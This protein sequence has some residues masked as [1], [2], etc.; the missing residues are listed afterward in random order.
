MASS[1]PTRSGRRI[2]GR[3]TRLARLGAAA[4]AAT[5]AHAASAQSPAPTYARIFGDHA[6]LQRDRPIAIWGQARPGQ[7]VSVAMAGRSAGATADRDGRWRATLAAIPAGGP[8]TLS[9]SADGAATTLT[10]IMVGDVYLCGGQSNMEFPARQSTGAWNGFGNALN[11]DLRFATVAKDSENAPLADL[12]NPAPWQVASPD[13][14]GEASAVCYYMARS[15]QKS[16]H[17]PVGFVAS[18]WGGTTIQGWISGP[19]LATVKPYDRG[20][21]ALALLARDPAAALAGQDRQEQDWWN[22]HDPQARKE[23]AYVA[24]RFNDAAWPSFTPGKGWKAAQVPALADFDGVV[25][26]R[27]E[28]V[29]TAEQARAATRLSLGQVDAADSSWVN[30]RPVGSGT[31]WW[32]GRDYPVPAGTFRAGRNVIVLR[33]LGGS[34]GGG[35]VGDPAQRAIMSEHG[36]VLPLDGSWKYRRGTAMKGNT[37]PTAPWSVPSS[38]ATLF[39]GMIAPITGYG[40]K[41]AAWYQGESNAGAAREYATLLPLLIAD[42]RRQTATPDLPFLLVQLAGFGPVAPQPTQSGWAELR[43]VQAKVARADPHAGLATTIDVGDRFD[44]H[45]TQKLVVGERLA[46]AARAVA[47]GEAVVPGGPEAVSVS[48]S[49]AD[50]VVAF[51]N[52]DAGLRTYS[53]GEAIGFEVCEGD[54]CRFVPARVSGSGIVL[55]GANGPRVTRVRYA[56]ADAPVVNLFSTDDLPAVPFELPVR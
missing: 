49:G 4:L 53:A 45:P 51:R 37:P 35:L 39:N 11:R 54:A 23:R 17:V 16:E 46:R 2:F 48:R 44:I 40:F 56:W 30:G 28:V 15:L 47:Y 5:L 31:T 41:L 24:P 29:L 12:K 6:V 25:W 7:A 21:A 22:A 18:D 13:T 26:L 10:D 20:V 19:A 3:L 42:W 52:A 38:Q 43:D 33:V 8:Y 50:L 1:M 14:V 55:A 34:N 32:A 36:T 9:A 27:K